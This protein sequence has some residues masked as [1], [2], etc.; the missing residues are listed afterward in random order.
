[1][2]DNEQPEPVILRFRGFPPIACAGPAITAIEQ[3]DV[4]REA[5]RWAA[6]C[7]WI[8]DREDIADLTDEQVIAGIRAHYDGGWAQFTRDVAAGSSP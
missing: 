1:M 6:D 7:E 2:N 4:I 5:R 3:A 8:E